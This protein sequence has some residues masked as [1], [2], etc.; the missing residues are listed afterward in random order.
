ML[1]ERYIQTEVKSKRLW[2]QHVTL[3]IPGCL[4]L[5]HCLVSSTDS[6]VSG[7]GF[8]FCH[9]LFFPLLASFPFY[10]D[11]QTNSL[12]SLLSSLNLFF[13]ICCQFLLLLLMY[14]TTWVNHLVLDHPI[15]LFPWTFNCN[16]LLPVL[17][18]SVLFRW[19]NHCTHFSHP[20]NKFWTPAFS[21]KI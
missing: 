11:Q 4:N 3:R 1:Q 12:Q 21:S 20:N 8:F 10:T 16:T 6:N 2:W 7:T 18:L 17:V 15:R 5:V 9:H 13:S 14:F 19:P